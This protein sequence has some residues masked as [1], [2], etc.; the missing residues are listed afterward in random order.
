VSVTVE[1]CWDTWAENIRYDV[2]VAVGG[3][4]VF[5]EEAVDHRRLSRWRMVF[6]WPKG[7]GDPVHVAHDFV[8]LSC[9]RER[10]R[11]SG[12]LSPAQRHLP[13]TWFTVT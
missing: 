1:N 5:D 6:F 4:K 2:S 12:T 11:D 13:P 9:F 10:Y 8:Y 7:A 3:N